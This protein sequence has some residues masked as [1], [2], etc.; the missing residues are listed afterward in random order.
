MESPIVINSQA[1][2]E[3]KCS[4]KCMDHFSV[5]DQIYFFNFLHC[6]KCACI[7]GQL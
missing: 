4:H 2:I 3:L 6:M 1:I 7:A 5:S